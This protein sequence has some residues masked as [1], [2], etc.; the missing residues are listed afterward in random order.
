[1]DFF[2]RKGTRQYYI[3]VT[4]DICNAETRARKIRPYLMLNDQVRKVIVV[5]KPIGEC[6]DDNGF[7]IIGIT[8]FLLD[9]I[10]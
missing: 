2:A 4:D 6:L 1:M 10:N 7:C 9:F 3:Q 5:N 8:V